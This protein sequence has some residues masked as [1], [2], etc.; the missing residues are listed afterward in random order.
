M[1]DSR[2]SGSAPRRN[3]SGI[4]GWLALLILWMVVLRPVGGL[5]LWRQ[6]H[7][8]ASSN[9]SVVAESTWLVNTSI[10]WFIFL[11]V[12]AL[13]IHGGLRLWRDRT[14]S[15]VRS[16]IVILWITSPVATA[17]LLIAESYLGG[18]TTIYGAASTLAINIAVAAAWTAYLKQ[19][20]RVK[21][22]Y[23]DE[24]VV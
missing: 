24:L 22:T 4:G 13:S 5:Q 7:A 12:A 1:S 6:M 8:A 16:A 23:A 20:R 15:A 21:S 11:G 18:D 19:S 3:P 17:A 14:S 9:P 10:F 2:T